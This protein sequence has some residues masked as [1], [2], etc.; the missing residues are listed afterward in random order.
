MADSHH[1]LAEVV[2]NLPAPFATL[3]LAIQAGEEIVEH[4]SH[5]FLSDSTFVIL[6]NQRFVYARATVGG[7]EKFV[8]LSL[9]DIVRVETTFQWREGPRGYWFVLFPFTWPWALMTRRLKIDVGYR[10]HYLHLP[11]P[12][13]WVRLL[14][15]SD[16]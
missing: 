5:K 1:P 2:G 11:N 15:E 6:T 14:T 4:A 12:E 8:K 9:P 7:M 16:E 3:D 13:K 10:S